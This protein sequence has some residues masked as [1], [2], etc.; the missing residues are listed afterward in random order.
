MTQ[1]V[2][3]MIQ[4]PDVSA[5]VEWYQ[6]IGFQVI[7]TFSD[8]GED[9]SWAMLSFGSSQIM[10]NE[11]GR[12]STEDRSEFNL[13]IY[14][15]DV[16]EL[17]HRLKDRVEITD[18]LHD[19][20][21]GMREFR[22]RDLNRVWLLFGQPSASQVLMAGIREGN[23]E[24]VQS[25]LDRGLKPEA[26]SAALAAALSGETRNAEIQEMLKKAGAKPP[27][28]VD[29][30]TLQSYAGKYR[31]EQGTEV[32]VR[33]EDGRL[34][35][36]WFTGQQPISLMPVDQTTFRPVGLDDVTVTFKVEGDRTVGYTLKQGSNTMEHTRITGAQQ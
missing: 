7:D 30:E 19:T 8:D 12:P 35:V 4:V 1:K 31:H 22:I 34:L 23:A 32:T 24:L 36:S 16:E 6:S 17:Y 15:D 26:L 10:F 2:V 18:G 33:L 13:Y 28:E 5:S 29:T 14:V 9:L 11:G 3:P 21:Y 20:M 25:A 27:Y